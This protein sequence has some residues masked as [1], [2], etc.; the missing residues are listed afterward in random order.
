MLSFLIVHSILLH[1]NRKHLFL[2]IFLIVLV[3][4]VKFERLYIEKYLLGDIT[5]YKAW[6]VIILYSNFNILSSLFQE[7]TLNAI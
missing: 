4:I 7:T 2:C 3:P 5:V 1:K 6:H